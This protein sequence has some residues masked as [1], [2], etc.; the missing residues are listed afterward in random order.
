MYEVHWTPKAT[1]ELAAL[2]LHHPGEWALINAS[3]EDISDKLKRQPLKQSHEV[4]EGLRRIISWRVVVYFS[5][6]G[7]RIIVD[8]V[9]W[10]G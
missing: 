4:S 10:I 3:E 8:A 6:D 7:N 5:I 9:G 2:C 1:D